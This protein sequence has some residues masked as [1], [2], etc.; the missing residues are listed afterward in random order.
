MLRGKI[1]KILSLL[2]TASM[3]VLPVY[4]DFSISTDEAGNSEEYIEYEELERK[5]G[6]DKLDYNTSVFAKICSTYKVTIPKV[7]VLSGTS[8]KADYQVW[9]EGDLAGYEVLHVV[10]ESTVDLYS[11]NKDVQV[12]TIEQNTTAWRWFEL[13]DTTFGN[14]S[15]NDITAG[16]WSGVFYFNI[17][18]EEINE[19][20]VLGDI[21]L[22]MNL[23]DDYR[24]RIKKIGLPGIYDEEGELIASY[25]E[26]LLAHP[27][28]NIE[29]DDNNVASILNTSYPQA[30]FVSLP[31][32]VTR[33]G[34]NT[35]SDT[36][37]EYV[38]IPNSVKEIGSNAF[39]E[40]TVY[41]NIPKSVTKVSRNNSASNVTYYNNSPVRK[42]VINLEDNDSADVELEKGCRY[43]IEALYNFVNNVTKESTIVSSNENIVKFVPECY[44]DAIEIGNCVISGT[45]YTQDGRQK[46]AEI[47][48]KVVN[49]HHVAAKAVR[50]KVVDATCTEPGSY[51]EVIRCRDCGSEMSR[52]KKT[53]PA[54]GH[55][56]GEAKI[57]NETGNSFDHVVRCKVC[58]AE[59]SRTRKTF[60]A[61]EISKNTLARLGYSYQS[62][63]R[64]EYNAYV[65]NGKIVTSM[66]IPAT[67]EYNGQIYKFTSVGSRTFDCSKL[68]TIVLP[69]T[70]TTVNN[71]AFESCYNL[72]NINLPNSIT[73][74]GV[75]AFESC[76]G[77]TS[78]SWPETVKCIKKYTFRFCSNLITTIPSS[79]TAIETQ[80]FRGC[81][82]IY[83][84][85]SATGRPWEAKAL[86]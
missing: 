45:Y 3:S 80:A 35:F 33:I 71:Y 8:K 10:P 81:K 38:N 51:E 19:D 83:Y 2:L 69:D 84:Y 1:S 55:T 27:D 25:D 36:S 56:K 9:V 13:A 31:S 29:A 79:V 20:L 57:E 65:K 49:P 23:D 58:N 34:N 68:T 86:N 5:D 73:Y 22:P 4:A 44:L 21:I 32:N 30:R 54:K 41:T 46:Y 78:I 82:H 75:G 77:L 47:K 6:D 76:S 14:V 42:I 50:E 16:K 43:E 64:S 28:F 7:I 52:V 62:I 18:I 15:A 24:L 74:I 70:I 48:I 40:S 72:K 66:T 63:N 12:G 61:S 11:T 37:I 60:V 67:Y 17:W 26:V 53:I 39:S 59:L 85:G